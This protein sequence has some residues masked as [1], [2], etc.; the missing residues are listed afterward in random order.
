[1][2]KLLTVLFLLIFSITYSQ[3]GVGYLN[4]TVYNEISYNGGYG[5]YAN[6]STDFNNMFN[7]ANGATIYH[8]GIGTASATLNY[9][10]SFMAAVPNG[11]S[12]FGIKTTGFFIPKETGTYYFSVDGDDGVDFSINGTV[13]T[14]YYGPHGFGG[15]HIGSI[16][17]V[18]GQV[19]T[20]MARF[21][22][23]G[24]GWGISVVWK[25]PSQSTYTLQS[26]EC[27]SVVA[28]PTKKAVINYN[29]NNA[30]TPSNF[31]ANVYTNNSNTW[32]I[33]SMNTATSLGSN[34]SANIT[35]SLDS[36]KITSG[37]NITVTAGQVEWSYVNI[38]NGVTTLYVD[39][40]QFGNVAPSSVTNV[41][42][43]DVYSGPVTFTSNDGT[44]A[45]YIVPST[46]P[47]VTNGTSS[48]NSN[49]RNAGYNNYAFSC[50][51]AFNN[52][53]AYKPQA[54]EL[55]TSSNLTTL[56]NS[57]VT[58]SDVYLAFQEYSNQGLFGNTSGTYFTSGIQYLNADVNL[59]GQFN[60]AD[61]YLLLANLTGKQ[62]LLTTVTLPNII[63]TIDKS[64]YDGINHNNWQL[65]SNASSYIYPINLN[66][67]KVT[68][69]FNVSV[70]WLGDVNMSHS[71]SQTAGVATFSTTNT[72]KSFSL[73]PS[74]Q[75][76]SSIIT[77]LIGD[78]VYVTITLNPLQQQVVGVQYQ[79]NYDNSI[80]QYQ[81]TQFNTIG[82]STNFATNKTNYIDLGSLIT[83]GS[84]NLNNTTVYKLV[85]TS[86]I[87]LN[88]VLGLIS[89]TPIDAVNQS[90]T[91]LK[92]TI[93]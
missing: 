43:L 34:G 29:F 2:K 27:Y 53:M 10:G 4:Y 63:K 72:I 92:I 54:V 13:V 57:I 58:V 70:A 93:N 48:Y 35:N 66:D 85:F 64:T 36:T 16:N 15:Y 25:R 7:T 6:S 50:T 12:Y 90:G 49:I 44:W 51:I 5:S 41:S 74:N 62:S 17:L 79:I 88:N 31:S 19:Y 78:S 21:Q 3:N 32:A 75:I 59:D 11:G 24:G 30:I 55:S 18:A 33:N 82:N 68:D 61:C 28:T 76:Q 89:I 38:F 67:T 83:D 77:Q 87:K 65:Y 86:N 40:R 69:T 23:V 22:Q 39:M 9:N 56:Y 71:I 46:L 52:L 42:I 84:S 60:E 14:S 47:I 26:D 73:A 45:Q 91:Q 81:R 1:M 8:S 80:L 37:E 20:L